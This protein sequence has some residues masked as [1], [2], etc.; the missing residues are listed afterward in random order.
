MYTDASL[1]GWGAH[2]T[3]HMAQGSCPVQEQTLHINVL[4]MKAVFAMLFK[5][6]RLRSST[7][8]SMDW[9]GKYLY[10]FPP[11]GVIPQVMSKLQSS[12]DC[13][14]LLIAPYWPKA[15]VN[16]SSLAVTTS[17]VSAQTASDT[18]V[19]QESQILEPACIL[20]DNYRDGLDEE[21]QL[22]IDNPH[23][24]STSKVFSGKWEIFQKMV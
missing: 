14:L 11:L 7:N 16:P 3:S 18:Q 5:H 9:A 22:R 23:G 20:A 13:K 4:E 19:S 2:C 12:K 6:L 1:E 24:Q 10:A 17:M 15:M 21:I 8:L